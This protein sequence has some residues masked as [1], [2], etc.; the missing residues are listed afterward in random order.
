M[1][2]TGTG[3]E[4]RQKSIRIQFVL[5]GQI[6]RERVTLNGKSLPPTPAN[7]KYATRL[8]LEIKRSIA[9]G[10][11]TFSEFFPDSARA[12]THHTEPETFAA[13]AKLWLESKGRLTIA[14]RSQYATAVRFW[15]GLLGESTPVT[16]INHKLLSA[17]IGG[18]PWPSAKTHNNYLIA[19]RGIIESA[20]R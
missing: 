8:A 12:K 10:T 19:L 1:G 7:I 16:D 18:Y 6:I 9:Q 2:R 11:F 3:I 17:K 14:T 15:E 4:V 20:Y 5:D 13:L